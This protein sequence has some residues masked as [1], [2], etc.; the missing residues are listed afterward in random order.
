MSLNEIGAQ[1]QKLYDEHEAARD[2]YFRAFATVNQKFSAIGKGATD[3]NP[4]SAEL[5]EY[6]KT[7]HAWQDVLR[8]IGEFVKKHV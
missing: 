5:S 8:R 7:R 1:W 4:T 2:A 6:E 3:V